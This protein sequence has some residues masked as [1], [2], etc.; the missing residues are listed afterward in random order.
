MTTILIAEDEERIAAF[1]AKGLQKAGYQTQV[2]SDGDQALKLALSDRYDL[3]LLD[4][5]LPG[6]DGWSI[7]HEI[8]AR[9][10]S[11]PVIVVTAFDGTEERNHSLELGA[12]EYVTKPFRFDELLSL[13]R[14]YVESA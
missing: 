7:L 14:R 5:G 9:S 11:P 13:I 4:I 2:V 3:M 6:L 12:D 1:I 8:R 10:A